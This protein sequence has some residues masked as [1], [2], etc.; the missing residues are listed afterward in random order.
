MEFW[1]DYL[2]N[3]INNNNNSKTIVITIG[4]SRGHTENQALSALERY[5]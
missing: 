4:L 5:T 3:F 1:Y 2:L